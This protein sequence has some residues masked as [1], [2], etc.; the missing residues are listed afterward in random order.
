MNSTGIL[1]AAG[2]SSE[3]LDRLR[4]A[5]SCSRAHCACARGSMLHCPAHEDPTPSLSSRVDGGRLLVHCFG[6]CS[7]LEVLNALRSHGLWP[8]ASARPQEPQPRSVQAEAL[9]LA[10]RQPWA[11]P[12][13]LPLYR[14][15]DSIRRRVRLAERLRRAAQLAGDCGPSWNALAHAAAFERSARAAETRLDDP[16]RGFPRAKGSRP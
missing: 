4:A 5:L 6:G 1:A 12:G 11:R 16:R 9:A 10:H 7:Q 13:V 15:A 2:S 3:L 8:S 14:T